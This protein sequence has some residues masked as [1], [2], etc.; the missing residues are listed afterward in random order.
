MQGRLAEV[1]LS[2]S[3]RNLLGFLLLAQKSASLRRLSLQLALAGSLG[4]G[5]LGV[6]LLLDLPLTRLLGLGLVNLW[7]LSAPG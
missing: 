3:R 6:H 4:A 2:P 5:T 7:G 1:R